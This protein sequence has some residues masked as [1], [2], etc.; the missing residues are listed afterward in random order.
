[1]KRNS[2]GVAVDP[3]LQISAEKCLHPAIFKTM[4]VSCGKVITPAAEKRH[5]ND[6]NADG[7]QHASQLSLESSNRGNSRGEAPA[8]SNS[9][10]LLFA[11]GQRLLLSKEE[12]LRVQKSKSTGLQ[13]VRKLALVLDLD[14]TLVHATG[15]WAGYTSSLGSLL[16]S[17]SNDIRRIFIEEA[18]GMQ[19]KCYL[20]KSR[21]HLEAFLKEAHALFQ[22]TIYTAGTRLYAEAVAKLMDPMG[23]YFARRIVSRSD[24]PNDKSEGMEK[25]LQRI[26]L[27]DASMVAIMDDREDVWKG[28]QAAQLLLVRPF[29]YFTGCEEVNNSA[30]SP[31]VASGPL[32]ALSGDRPGSIID[33]NSHNRQTQSA[34]NSAE[35]SNRSF[36]VNTEYDDQLPRCLEI[37]KEIHKTFFSSMNAEDVDTGTSK[38]TESAIGHNTVHASVANI[39]DNMKS[40]ILAGCTIAFSGVIPV[41]SVVEMHPCWRLAVSLGASVSSEV[42]KHTTH[43]LS[44]SMPPPPGASGSTSS[45]QYLTSKAKEC[46][47][48][49]DVWVLHPD[50]LS[51]CR[52]SLA[53]AEESTFMLVAQT[54]GKPLPNPIMRMKL[55]LVPTVQ[56]SV[57]DNSG[58]SSRIIREVERDIKLDE[59]GIL[60]YWNVFGGDGTLTAPQQSE[61]DSSNGMKHSENKVRF[62]DSGSDR[63]IIDY[64]DYSRDARFEEEHYGSYLDSNGV[65]H[66]S[67]GEDDD[68]EEGSFDNFDAIIMQR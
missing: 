65:D 1:M 61:I 27:Q 25:S 11:G 32:I 17:N 66:G 30:G 10:S 53:R 7:S 68:S 43:L 31:P 59:N 46:L 18:P 34:N 12:A 6:L 39:I 44:V 67:D 16:G 23:I 2:D 37:L 60:N 19:P 22:M 35:Q 26:F 5:R 29:H 62:A 41:K 4:C 3:K 21:P 40:P 54:P 64:E 56:S 13:S 38:S 9:S 58:E 52:Y 14:H 28:E 20:V 63:Q 50:W 36:S 49:G 48:R 51:Y 57:V 8:S 47:C 15:A 55:D 42:T 45:Q 33:P 24:V